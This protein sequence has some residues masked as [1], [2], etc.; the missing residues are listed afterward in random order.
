MENFEKALALAEAGY[1]VFPLDGSIPLPETNGHLDATSDLEK[2]KKLWRA[3]NWNVGVNVG[4]SGVVVLDIDMKN[5]KDG[6]A[7]LESE[8]YVV[9]ES[10]TFWYDTP[11]GG[12]HMMYA[13]PDDVILSPAAPYRKLEG[14]DRRGGSSYVVFWGDRVPGWDEILPAPEWLCDPA[15]H[16]SPDEFDGDLE[17][18]LSK[19][20]PGEPNKMVRDAIERIPLDMGHGEMVAAQ[21]NAVRLGAE[22][23]SGV[24]Q[25]LGA[26]REAWLARDP[27]N[28]TTPE[29]KWDYKFDEALRSGIQK[30]GAAIERIKNLPNYDLGILP[31]TFRLDVLVGSPADDETRARA[32]YRDALHALVD[33]DL[34]D[35]HIASLLWSAPRTADLSREWMID[36]VYERIQKTRANE[37]PERENPTLEEEVPNLSEPQISTGFDLLEDFE[38]ETLENRPSFIDRYLEL[39]KRAGFANETYFRAAGWTVLSM[40]FAFRGFIPVSGADKMG[41]NLWNQVLG[42]SGTGKAQPLD[43][44]VLTPTGF[45][46]MGDVQVGDSVVVPSGG[47]ASVTGVFPQGT[48]PIYR[49]T[50]GDGR[51]VNADADHLWSVVRAGTSHRTFEK[52]TTDLSADLFEKGGASSKWFIETIQPPDLGEWSSTID[53]YSLGVILGDAYVGRRELSISNVDPAIREHIE[54][55]LP[56]SH[57]VVA[58]DEVT[59]RVR[60]AKSSDSWVTELDRLGLIG[61]TASTKFIPL[62]LKHSSSS[63]RLAL[64][65]GILD[66]DGT[67]NN[68]SGNSADIALASER[69]VDDIRWL[70]HSLGGKA[71]KSEKKVKLSGWDEARVYYRLYITLPNQ[72]DLFRLERK[73][74]KVR[75]GSKYAYWKSPIRDIKFVEDAP[76]QCILVDHPDH[77]YVTDGFVRT[78]NTRATKFRDAVL[79]LMF[80]GDN[81]ETG[82]SLGSDSSPQGLQTALLQRDRQ[83]SFLGADEASRFFKQLAKTDW[84]SGF[85]DVLSHYY[86]GRVDPSNK[87]NLRELRGKT[88]LTSFSIQM[89]AT[90]DRLTEVLNRDMFLTGFLARFN[91]ILGDPPVDTDDRFNMLQQNEPVDFDEVSPEVEEIVLDL[92]Q[93]ARMFGS[94]PRPILA[95]PAALERMSLAYRR[96]YREA[97]KRENWDIIEPSITR[98]AET[99][100]K[101]AALCAMYRGSEEIDIY[102]A[103]HAIDAVQEWYDNLFVVAA[104]ISSGDFQRDANRIEAW[105]RQKGGRVTRARLYHQFG[106]LIAK[107]PRE[108]DAKINFLVESGRINRKD[109]SGK[110]P[111]YELNGG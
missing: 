90:P 23:A 52:T 20:T 58:T 89:F 62:A 27:G 28:H 105:I 63:D 46:R 15:P 11:R 101:C 16:L 17:D 91:W 40:A 4:M 68:V 24:E 59:Y 99:M 67:P 13:A 76:T 95:T 33:T 30:Y 43:A 25:L 57:S 93:A 48:R 61:H 38:R 82:Y 81:D 47:V 9:D 2:V 3:G 109:E 66:T 32:Y 102:D 96:M 42:Y 97:Q 64:L 19:L 56:E 22:G 54:S 100:R 88:A 55:N 86:E 8:W 5:G 85:D 21:H 69:L 94:N 78:H 44:G 53:P 50:L 10:D 80:I 12:R 84:M 75:K 98:L 108:L 71:S 72:F 106:N 18:W 39:G 104:M 83:A 29:E 36:F 41:L 70:V 92:V 73:R 45:K 74:A 34:D 1:A 103:Y 60:T 14:I 110:E 77:E 107:D 65:Q 26:I 111:R 79:N 37:T 31:D 7:T 6:F 87:I 35:D 49:V 51:T